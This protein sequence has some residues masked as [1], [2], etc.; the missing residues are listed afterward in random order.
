MGRHKNSFYTAK[1]TTSRA[2][3][4]EEKLYLLHVEQ[5]LNT[6]NLQ[7]ITEKYQGN[8]TDNGQMGKYTEYTPC[9]KDTQ[10][11]NNDLL[12]CSISLAIKYMQLTSRSEQLS[13]I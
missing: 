11:A 9:K 3:S 13:L 7:R 10:M 12:K 8:K 4:L 6:Q 2:H 5:V 1:E